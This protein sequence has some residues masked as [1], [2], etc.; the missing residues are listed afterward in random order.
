M[1]KKNKWNEKDTPIIIIDGK[2]IKWK[3]F[4][5]KIEDYQKIITR[6]F[7]FWSNIEDLEKLSHYYSSES[8][9]K[10]IPHIKKFLS[11]NKPLNIH[12]W[13][14]ELFF[15]SVIPFIFTSY[16]ELYMWKKWS[17]YENYRSK[18]NNDDLNNIP[19]N[20]F[21]LK[22]IN[23][24]EGPKNLSK[25]Q[26]INE[27]RNAIEH[28]R[29]I[30][31]PG[32]IYINNPKTTDPKIH[33]HNFKAVIEYKFL[34]QFIFIAPLI[35]KKDHKIY[36]E[37]CDN[38]WILDSRKIYNEI[39]N[40]IKFGRLIS[41]EDTSNI[42][43]TEYKPT[44]KIQKLIESFYTQNKKKVSCD[45]L[46]YIASFLE[47]PPEITM[48][49][50]LWTIRKW[51]YE[52]KW[53]NLNDFIKETFNISHRQITQHKMIMALSKNNEAKKQ[54]LINLSNN[55]QK[56]T[57]KNWQPLLLHTTWCV[58]YVI[59]YFKKQWLEYDDINKCRKNKKWDFQIEDES[60]HQ[61]IVYLTSNYTEIKKCIDMFPNRLKI[62]FIKSVYLNKLIPLD[63]EEKEHIRNA[64]AHNRYT[65]LPWIEDINLRDTYDKNN[66]TYTRE[67]NYNLS[68]L[69]EKTYKEMIN[70]K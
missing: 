62:Q 38:I 13:N 1:S 53:M 14:Y 50:I 58:E 16:K 63:N 70:N 67:E 54:F 44:Q 43:Q 52:R 8:I 19:E 11:W 3:D 41:N 45:N 24:I 49:E 26:I 25:K 55:I 4:P 68:D 9:D 61:I 17:T 7:Y 2:T 42:T 10:T 51:K 32:W 48:Y 37:K 33:D 47:D 22:N 21:N 64:L 20:F 29:Y 39:E 69:Y 28:T 46:S 18:I 65:I 27:I 15:M 5:L 35:T 40:T 36:I 66:D 34:Q 30:S 56:K 12:D 59:E 31:F 23:I 6:L 57:Q 60:I